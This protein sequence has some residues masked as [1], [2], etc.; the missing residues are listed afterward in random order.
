MQVS[1][2]GKQFGA[3]GETAG[4]APRL[5]GEKFDADQAG[6]VPLSAEVELVNGGHGFK[7]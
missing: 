2:G 1:V 7:V 3:Q 6:Q 5:Q 4:E